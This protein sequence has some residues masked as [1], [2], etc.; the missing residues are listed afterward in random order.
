[1]E[2]LTGRRSLTAEAAAAHTTEF[3][4]FERV[5]A[6][7]DRID[8]VDP[9]VQAFLPEPDRR[10]RLRAQARALLDR[11]PDPADRPPLFGVPVGV[12]DIVRVDGLP[13]RGG[14]ALAP[15]LF[16][17][18]ALGGAQAPV[19]DRLRA[20]GA[21]V[22]GKTVTAEFAILAPGP[23][24]NPHDPGHTPGGSSSGSAA[25]VAAGM[26][27]LAIG[28]QTVGSTIRPAAY[29]GVVGFK[30]GFGRIPISGVIPN[31]P[32]QDTLG[33]FTV[34][35]AGAML[36]A[37]TLCDGWQ[38]VPPGLAPPV[39]GVPVGP[40][41]DKAEPEA[42]AAFEEQLR[43]LRTA[44][45]TVH[46]VPAMPDF[47]QV[48]RR[49]YVVNRYEAAQSHADWFARYRELY[50]EETAAVIR[51]GQAIDRD[52]YLRAL[53]DQ[54]I[55][56]E[57]MAVAMFSEGVDMWLT[58]A[59]TGPAPSGLATTG[60][61]IMSLP[62]SFAGFPAVN[63]P[64]A[65]TAAGLPL[66]L[67]C[68]GRPGSDERVLAW[69]EPIET[70]LQGGFRAG[71]AAAQPISADC[72]PC[73]ARCRG[74]AEIGAEVPGDQVGHAF[75]GPAAV[76][77][78]HPDAELPGGAHR[79]LGQDAVALDSV[80]LGA[81]RIADLL[82]EPARS[83]QSANLV[84]P[85]LVG[86]NH[87]D[88][89]ARGVQERGHQV[90]PQPPALGEDRPARHQGTQVVEHPGEA[91][92]ES[93]QGL[94]GHLL[95][96]GVDP[97]RLRVGAVGRLAEVDPPGRAAVVVRAGVVVVV[98]VG[99]DCVPFGQKPGHGGLAGPLAAGDPE[100]IADGAEGVPRH[101]SSVS[102]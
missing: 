14:S 39:L 7:C 81:F 6:L 59:A 55:F 9:I 94:G 87:H 25:A 8:A 44:G 2:I 62:W 88:H 12:K 65:R 97:D 83:R 5:E 45:F 61:S 54:R 28:T 47:E 84:P 33:M 58:P 30:P 70:L 4:L 77:L 60:S 10:G 85:E 72:F 40:Y 75:G 86:G 74:G 80:A 82:A 91:V 49:Q 68:V 18:A 98:V 71:D 21:L 16:G 22:A 102:Q 31:V 51:T 15:E 67:Q 29:C 27:P 17:G 69:A 34:D 53:S 89:A 48:V 95:G 13:T 73:A 93:G 56:R 11:R 79:V 37:E 50:R 52:D 24:R 41:L 96:G 90:G 36:A 20:A 35:V 78:D 42:R 43:R 46:E 64:A 66:G 99:G 38:P 100:G 26:L 23:T 32:S 101:G 1:M 57:Q 92:G 3:D 19:V 63:I 76:H